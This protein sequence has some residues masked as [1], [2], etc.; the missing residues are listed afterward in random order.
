MDAW[1]EAQIVWINSKY[2][3]NIFQ[4]ASN[5][6]LV[7]HNEDAV[8]GTSIKALPH[9]CC[10]FFH[11]ILIIGLSN[12]HI[13]LCY[14]AY[15]HPD[16]FYLKPRKWLFVFFESAMVSCHS[17]SL[18]SQYCHCH[19]FFFLFAIK[20]SHLFATV[21][22]SSS[23]GKEAFHWESRMIVCVLQQ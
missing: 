10:F 14:N 22:R 6:A 4:G 23:S 5:G 20:S 1:V 18:V 8:M 17:S 3:L 12:I 21:R 9:P 15:I 11:L 16:N 2:I 13:W 19:F 7:R